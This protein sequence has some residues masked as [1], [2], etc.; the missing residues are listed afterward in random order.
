[1]SASIPPDLKT[2]S[3]TSR[4][5]SKS[6]VPV[7]PL[8]PNPTFGSPA[9]KLFESP[10]ATKNLFISYLKLM[11]KSSLTRRSLKNALNLLPRDLL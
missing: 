6:S 9:E 8:E 1:M 11:F 5:S 4:A 10:S 2:Q 7:L 3:A